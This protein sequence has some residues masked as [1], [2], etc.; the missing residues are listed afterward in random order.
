[1]PLLLT[2][3]LASLAA[4]TAFAGVGQKR[5]LWRAGSTINI[6]VTGATTGEI[7]CIQETLKVFADVVPVRFRLRPASERG[8]RA[9]VKLEIQR[10]LP[11]G[12]IQSVGHSS[13]GNNFWRHETMMLKMFAST[14]FEG[15]DPLLCQ[16][17]RKT[18]VHEFGHLL[19]LKHEHQHPGAPASLREIMLLTYG[20]LAHPRSFLP[21]QPQEMRGMVLTPYDVQS[22]MHYPFTWE[23]SMLDDFTVDLREGSSGNVYLGGVDLSDGDRA[24]LRRMYP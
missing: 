16:G 21:Y 9:Q 3:L 24:T 15:Y 20:P 13:V 4:V 22:V 6:A 18:I 8:P 10:P 14:H 5:G 12:G 11:G 19:G 1:M 7:G 2:L 23:A 17:A